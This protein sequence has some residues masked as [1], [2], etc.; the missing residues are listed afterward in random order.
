VPTK[1]NKTRKIKDPLAHFILSL[2]EKKEALG[3][4]RMR[5]Q[6]E[7]QTLMKKVKIKERTLKLR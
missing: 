1:T 3:K 2:K 6:L 4:K 5:W 7:G